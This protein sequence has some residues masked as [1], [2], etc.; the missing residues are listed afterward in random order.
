MLPYSYCCR[1]IFVLLN[2]ISPVIHA[3]YSRRSRGGPPQKFGHRVLCGSDPWIVD[4]N[5]F[6][7]SKIYIGSGFISL[8]NVL[9]R[10]ISGASSRPHRELTALSQ[11]SL[12][13][14]E[15]NIPKNHTPLGPFELRSS[16]LHASGIGYSVLAI[17]VEPHNVVDA[18]AHMAVL[19]DWRGRTSLHEMTFNTT[20]FVSSGT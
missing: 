10:Q 15:E 3:H 16:V 12:A 13:G 7:I 8:Q 17:S 18:S 11:S 1:S 4:W 6:N 14:V 19:N 5:K 9:S 20:Y 2:L